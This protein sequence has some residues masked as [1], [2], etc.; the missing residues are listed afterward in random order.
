M[1]WLRTLTR[2]QPRIAR[3]I[4]KLQEYEFDV[5]HRPGSKNQNADALSRLPLNAIFIKSDHSKFELLNKQKADPDCQMLMQALEVGVPD[6]LSGFASYQRS[7]LSRIREFEVYDS[8]LIRRFNRMGKPLSQVFV[9]S[10]MRTDVLMAFHDD[11]TGG[12]LSRDKIL[13]KIRAMY[14]WPNLEDDV[15][16]LCKC[17]LEC[18]KLKPPPIMPIAPMHPIECSRPFELVTSI[19]AARTRFRCV[20]TNTFLSLR[21]TLQSGWRPTRYRIRKLSLPECVWSHSSTLSATLM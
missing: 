11:P 8:V 17:C 19:F 13:G 6:D 3:W 7:F 12:H 5:V 16:R 20:E 10:S 1:S 14:Y 9:P 4:L 2:F 18:Q 21:T 15:K